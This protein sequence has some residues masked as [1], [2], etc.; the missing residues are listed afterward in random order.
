MEG[1]LA[2][3]PTRL[4]AALRA[5]HVAQEA[6]VAGCDTERRMASMIQFCRSGLEAMIGE[7]LDYLFCNEEKPRSGVAHRTLAQSA[8]SAGAAFPRGVPDAW[9]ARLRGA[10]GPTIRWCRHCSARGGHQWRGRHVCRAFLYAVTHGHAPC[11][12]RS[13][14]G[15][16]G[17]RPCRKPVRQPP[18]SIGHSRG[19]GCIRGPPPNA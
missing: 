2:A 19:K 18:E 13:L 7:G 5:R 8:S 14:A 16:S 3:S 17:G 12:L 9:C 1:Y 15:Q 6:G 4:D 10:G 11:H